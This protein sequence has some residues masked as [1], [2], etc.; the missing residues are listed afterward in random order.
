MGRGRHSTTHVNII[1]PPPPRPSNTH[2]QTHLSSH[3]PP[4][5]R[6]P[7]VPLL[8]PLL[9]STPLRSGL[10]RPTIRQTPLS[11]RLPSHTAL[12][13]TLPIPNFIRL[14]DAHRVGL[15]RL[16]VVLLNL[17]RGRGLACAAAL[18]RGGY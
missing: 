8:P 10:V 17:A 16:L 2:T 6:L 15:V 5:I 1:L 12:L 4:H 14:A 3:I 7:A 11:S 9:S 18:N 13:D